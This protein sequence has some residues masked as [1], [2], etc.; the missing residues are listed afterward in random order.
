MTRHIITA[1]LLLVTAACG[2]GPTEPSFTPPPIVTSIFTGTLPV[3]GSSVYSLIVDQASNATITM[4]SLAAGPSGAPVPATVGLALGTAGESEGCPRTIDRRVTPALTAQIRT[5]RTAGTHCVEIYDVGTLTTEVT[6]AI[7]I[8]VTPVANT[9]TQTASPGT[10]TFSSILTQQGSATRAVTASQAGTL[11]AT[12]TSATPPN[13]LVGL[14]LGIP[15][16]DAG[17][18]YLSTASNILTSAAAQ[19]A[20]AV[21]AGQYCVKVYDLGT[22][23]TNVSFTVA[24]NHP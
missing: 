23:T 17:G 19:V 15:R 24:A 13:L 1:G 12:M 21:D 5:E 9:S 3:Q 6:F 22:L 20:T 14:G 8:V 2:G 10:D 18:C 11:S 4:A 7:R 16:A